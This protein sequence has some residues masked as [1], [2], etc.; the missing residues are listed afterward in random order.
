MST[1]SSRAIRRTEGAAGATGISGAAGSAA[2]LAP[3]LIATTFSGPA[4]VRTAPGLSDVWR[5]W[6]STCCSSPGSSSGTF[7]AE[8][9]AT[10]G[11][12]GGGV[13]AL[14]L[15]RRLACRLRLVGRGGAVVNRED[16]L[17]DLDLVAGLDL[18]FLD[19]PG[20]RR[21]HLDGR[22]VGF[23]L[24]DRLVFLDHVAGLDEHAQHVARRD[25]FT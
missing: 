23:E 2:A 19:P 8:L 3:R 7:A 20:H 4:A 25:V 9:A 24:D 10:A 14:R 5:F 16:R 13:A 22:L 21:R 15:G 1:P 18:D 17:A 12:C 11:A 6:P